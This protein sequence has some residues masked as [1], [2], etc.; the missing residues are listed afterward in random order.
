MDPVAL[1]PG[2]MGRIRIF[3]DAEEGPLGGEE[4]PTQHLL[5]DEEPVEVISSRDGPPRHQHVALH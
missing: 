5:H 1:D 3:G 4:I 2:R